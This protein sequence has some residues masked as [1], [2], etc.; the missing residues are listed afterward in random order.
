MR[1][2]FLPYGRPSIGDTEI[3]AA[4]TCFQNGW[5][6]TGARVREFEEV[7]AKRAGVKYAVAVNSCTAAL[8][9]GLI[10]LGLGPGDEVIMP[11]LTFVAGAQCTREIGA[12]PVFADI[13]PET[14]C[15]TAA[16]IEAVLTPRTRAIIPMHYGGRPSGIADILALASSRGIRVL[17]DAAHA[18]GMLEDGRWS[19][20]LSDGAAYSFYPTKNITTGEGGMFVTNDRAMME[21]VR[22][23]SL[24]G[25][26]KDAWKRYTAGGS[27]R[28]DVVEPGYKYNLTDVAAA[29]GVVQ[30]ERLE[31]LQARRDAIARAYLK[32]LDGIPGVTP[33]S[34]MLTAPDR[35]SWCMFVVL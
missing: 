23:L 12:T 7:F 16:T 14:L 31:E 26:N 11:S 34:Q 4:M 8:H 6:T 29:M 3:A 1:E 33:A 15:M 30:L 21:R 32:A 27:W 28:Y 35:H 18:A 2:T 19:G 22:V 13:D 5:L 10:A 17:E 25:M 20:T 9:L 24:H